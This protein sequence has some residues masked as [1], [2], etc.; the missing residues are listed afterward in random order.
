MKRCLVCVWVLPHE[1]KVEAL[2]FMT[3]PVF[4]IVF[5]NSDLGPGH[6]KKRVKSQHFTHQNISKAFLEATQSH[7]RQLSSFENSVVKK[8]YRFWIC[9]PENGSYPHATKTSGNPVG[10]C[11][12][13]LS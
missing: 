1:R 11:S 13:S 9:F 7:W 2:S 10:V 5:G 4:T 8:K 6:L 12:S 3:L